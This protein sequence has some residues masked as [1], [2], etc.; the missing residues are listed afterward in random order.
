MNHD[1]VSIWINA[2][3]TGERAYFRDKFRRDLDTGEAAAGME[4]A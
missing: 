2:V 3:K 1:E 4:V